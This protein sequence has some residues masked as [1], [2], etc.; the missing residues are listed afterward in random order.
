M[1]HE[2]ASTD[3]AYRNAFLTGDSVSVSLT[4]VSHMMLAIETKV[5]ITVPFHM[6][7]APASHQQHMKRRFCSAL[8]IRV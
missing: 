4:I 1:V 7:S 2:I 8:C 3:S 6:A 5:R